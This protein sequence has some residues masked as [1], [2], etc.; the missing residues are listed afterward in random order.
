MEVRKLDFD[1]HVIISQPPTID[2]DVPRIYS[3]IIEQ[4]SKKLF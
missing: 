2:F 3:K 4:N 1:P